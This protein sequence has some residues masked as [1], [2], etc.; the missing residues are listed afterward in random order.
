MK[1]D[2]VADMCGGLIRPLPEDNSAKQVE[3]IG[4]DITGDKIEYDITVGQGPNTTLRKVPSYLCSVP[5]SLLP[6]PAC[7]SQ[8]P[9]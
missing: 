6:D 2:V 5:V 9:I 7:A 4:F 3:F 8:R 1:K